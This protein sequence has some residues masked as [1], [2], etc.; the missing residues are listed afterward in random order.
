M[1]AAAVL[2]LDVTSRIPDVVAPIPTRS[3]VAKQAQTS[4]LPHTQLSNPRQA[5]QHAAQTLVQAQFQSQ[6]QSQYQAQPPGPG[7]QS[8]QLPQQGQQP[9]LPKPQ[10][11]PVSQ[12]QPSSGPQHVHT[13]QQGLSQVPSAPQLAPYSQAQLLS[14]VMPR[15]H[16]Q[17]QAQ[18]PVTYSQAQSQA[19]VKYSQA[20]AQAPLTHPQAQSQPQQS[21][22]AL[23]VGPQVSQP[24]SHMALQSLVAQS[25]SQ[26]PTSQ[27]LSG[28]AQQGR[29]QPPAHPQGQSQPLSSGQ[30]LDQQ[31]ELQ[32][33]GQAQAAPLH[34]AS[35]QSLLQRPSSPAVS[36]HPPPNQS[37]GQPAGHNQAAV[38]ES[39]VQSQ[40]LSLQ[41]TAG[42]MQLIQQQ[43][44]VKQQPGAQ[45]HAVPA[46]SSNGVLASP[47][48]R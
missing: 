6:S 25:A 41:G 40:P 9:G 10:P 5:A 3:A 30:N 45:T 35:F 36:Q 46:S 26:Q 39:A 44:H 38:A 29:L 42:L 4:A 27:V 8:W 7:Q 2:G 16:A 22:S 43:A 34:P 17:A 47:H 31:A 33:N 24:L 32:P 48:V 14:L 11:Q 12:P 19:P 20:Q 13:S 23:L 18:P 28:Q 37:L 1:T 15:P 21:S